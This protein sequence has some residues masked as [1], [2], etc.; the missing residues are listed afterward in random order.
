ML[1]IEIR[2]KRY[3][4][5]TKG[6]I[7]RTDIPHTMSGQ[8]VFLGVSFHHLRKG[9]DIPFHPDTD[10]K[11]YIGGL[12]WDWDHGTTRQWGGSYNGKLPRI[13]QAWYTKECV[14]EVYIDSLV[15]EVTRR[16]NMTCEHCL[17]GD[18]QSMDMDIEYVNELFKKTSY[19]STITFTGGEPSMAY[20]TIDQILESA[21]IYGVDVG[22]FYIATNAKSIPDGFLLTLINLYVYCDDNEVSQ[23]E[24]SNDP[25]HENDETAIE[26]LKVFSFTGPKYSQEYPMTERSIIAEGKADDFGHRF[27]KREVF[28]TDT[29][30]NQI[31][32]GNLYLNCLGNVIAGCNW[33]YESQEEEDNII[34]HVGDFGID[35]VEKFTEEEKRNEIDK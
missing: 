23:V 31:M 7:Q 13:T 28:E 11:E 24:W 33:S 35:K 6:H 21:K 5:N 19:I 9:I 17:R 8:W 20:S 26:K 2:G 15:I 25:Y 22:N 16:C 14:Q 10:P 32:E 12:V 3:K 27:M 34:C 1:N 29:E 4:V 30:Y 18:Q